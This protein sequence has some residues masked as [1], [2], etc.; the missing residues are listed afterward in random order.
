MKSTANAALQKYQVPSVA[1]Y[2]CDVRTSLLAGNTDFHIHNHNELY[3]L[4]RGNIQY[5]VDSKCYPLTG[6]SLILFSE[7]EIHKA[8]NMTA[9]PFTRL[10]IHVNSSF[11]R[12]YC[13]PRTNLLACFQRIPGHGNLV[14]LSPEEIKKL[15]SLASEL[16]SAQA[17]LSAYGSDLTAI[18][19]LIRILVLVNLAWER[20]P[21]TEG[22][23]I[24]YRSSE[25]M[26]YIERHIS[27]PL[28]LDSVA[29]ALSMGK[30]Y[31]SHLF[32]AE[33][34][35]TVFQYI[36]VKRIAIARS[37]LSEGVS[38]TEAC[39]RSG[40]NDYSNFIRSFRLIT[41]TSPG[42]FRKHAGTP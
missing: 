9:E 37:L 17:D 13:T 25:I 31:M 4:I 39:E 21:E 5:F 33:T 23:E 18:S 42:Q 32:K 6:G 38:V 19:L 2:S 11:I 14:N 1:T 30:F 15:L 28:S 36:L 40:F 29:Q 34:G 16:R 22:T 3:F 12:P 35:S 41:G 7:H 26:E 20:M 10:V 24:R 8:L 27:E